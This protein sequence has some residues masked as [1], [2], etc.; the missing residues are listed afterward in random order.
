MVLTS[1]CLVFLGRLYVTAGLAGNSSYQVGGDSEICQ[2]VCL[3]L[4]VFGMPVP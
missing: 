2:C 1:S 3:I 4:V